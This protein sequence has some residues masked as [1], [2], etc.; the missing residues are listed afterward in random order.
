MLL[1]IELAGYLTP[2]TEASIMIV[3]YECEWSPLDNI[4]PIDSVIVLWAVTT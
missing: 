4:Y 2:D 1:T 3:T